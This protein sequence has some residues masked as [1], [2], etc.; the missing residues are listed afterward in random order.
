MRFLDIPGEEPTGMDDTVIGLL[1]DI[2][3]GMLPAVEIPGS[4]FHLAA[5]NGVRVPTVAAMAGAGAQDPLP[6]PARPFCRRHP[7]HRSRASQEPATS[8]QQVCPPAVAKRRLVPAPSVSRPSRSH[9]AQWGTRGLPGCTSVAQSR[10]HRPRWWWG[11]GR[12]ASCAAPA[13]GITHL[14]N[15]VYEFVMSKVQGDLPA[16]RPPGPAGQVAPGTDVAGLVRALA[17][18]Q[19][20]G[21][22]E[23]AEDGDREPKQITEVYRETY[24]TLVQTLQSRRTRRCRTLVETPAQFGKR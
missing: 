4:A 21:R 18:V 19:Q 23:R 15:L 13:P 7:R 10:Q 12:H 16:L 9:S 20:Q 11:A 2:R 1:G 17:E 22:R 14:P 3:P 8:T 24:T 5:A 6:L